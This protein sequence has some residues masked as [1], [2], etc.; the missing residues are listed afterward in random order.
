VLDTAEDNVDNP[1][2][3]GV[4]SLNV[5]VAAGIVM[6]RIRHHSGAQGRA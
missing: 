2:A 4:P 5:V 1:M 6:N 3:A